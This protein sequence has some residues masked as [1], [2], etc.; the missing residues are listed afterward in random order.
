MRAN[1]CCEDDKENFYKAIQDISFLFG[2]K[3]A[4]AL[5]KGFTAR[6]DYINSHP[7]GYIS[8]I[9]N[10]HTPGKSGYTGSI[11]QKMYFEYIGNQRATPEQ[12]NT[13][14]HYARHEITHI[15]ETVAHDI[16]SKDKKIR[17]NELGIP[18]FYNIKENDTNY[19]A[20]N[21]TI[22]G[23]NNSGQTIYGGGFCELFTDMMALL[24]NVSSND[25]FK[26][27][28]ITADMIL[29]GKTTDWN[30]NINITT[31]YLGVM[32]ILKLMIAAFS[33]DPDICYQKNIENGDGIVFSQDNNGNRIIANDFIYGC[34]CDPFYIKNTCDKI[35]GKNGY[36]Y[37]LCEKVD[38][39]VN[40]CAEEKQIDYNAMNEIIE[41]ISK[42]AM[43][44]IYMQQE[45]EKIDS[46]QADKMLKQFNMI[47]NN[48]Q[49]ELSDAL[50]IHPNGIHR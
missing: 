44:R 32:P 47:K 37:W 9:V 12:I 2:S 10:N 40:K 43:I 3:N 17:I 49:Q 21:G 19:A 6:I 27:K 36:Y 46:D 50:N 29:K 30:E 48:V 41:E 38:Y 18:E 45:S 42:L 4:A 24:S 20:I 8:N 33:N 22:Y 28:M 23:I 25:E 1:F 39:V 5:I 14:N 31:G 34:F 15:F 13:H 7:V 11:N 16:F 35:S 26:Q